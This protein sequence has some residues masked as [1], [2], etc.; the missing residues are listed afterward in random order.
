MAFPRLGHRFLRLIGEFAEVGYFTFVG[1]IVC[2]DLSLAVMQATWMDVSE[3]STS[4]V[5][6]TPGIVV[7]SWDLRI[8]RLLDLIVSPSKLTGPEV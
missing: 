8:V 4:S 6:L 2:H 3:V 7:L 1:L 5:L